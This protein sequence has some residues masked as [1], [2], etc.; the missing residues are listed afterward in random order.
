MRCASACA[1]PDTVDRDDVAGSKAH[2]RLAIALQVGQH[3]FALDAGLERQRS[4]AVDVDQL[5]IQ[6][7]GGYEVQTRVV[8]TLRGEIRQ[9]VGYAVVGVARFH[10]P[11]IAQPL[12]QLRVV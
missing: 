7:I 11:G 5:G 8:L 4:L 6:D 9:H 12:A 2:Q 3:Q 10:T 1:A